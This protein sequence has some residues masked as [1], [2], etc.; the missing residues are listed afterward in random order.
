MSKR[1]RVWMVCINSPTALVECREMF[2]VEQVRDARAQ[3]WMTLDEL[4]SLPQRL[5][6]AVSLAK[7]LQQRLND[8]EQVIQLMEMGVEL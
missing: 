3:G 2:S 7:T 4:R 8:K 6:D 5:A 1:T